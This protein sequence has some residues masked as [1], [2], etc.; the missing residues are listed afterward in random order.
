MPQKKVEQGSKLVE[1]YR[2]HPGGYVKTIQTPRKCHW[3]VPEAPKNGHSWAKKGRFWAL[4]GLLGDTFFGPLRP[5]LTA[6][7][8][9]DNVQPCSTL[10]NQCSTHLGWLGPPMAKYGHF[11]Q[12][13]AVFGRF[14]GPYVTFPGGLKGSIRPPWM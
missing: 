10:F 6:L 8:V 13:M 9:F 11:G 2:K 12:K 14:Q 4:Q 1:Q 7:D 5:K 3:G